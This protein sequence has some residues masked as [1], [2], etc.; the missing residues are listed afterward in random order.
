M[1]TSGLYVWLQVIEVHCK[2]QANATWL[3]VTYPAAV[4]CIAATPDP[5]NNPDRTAASTCS[6]SARVVSCC[7]DYRHI[8]LQELQQVLLDAWGMPLCPARLANRQQQQC[9]HTHR[10]PGLAA[11]FWLRCRSLVRLYSSHMAASA[12]A[13]A[14]CHVMS[15]PAGEDS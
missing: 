1:R 5:A 7:Y 8:L 10:S 2:G 14:V 9:K 13:H 15:W 11:V 12:T 6:R 4:V 3:S